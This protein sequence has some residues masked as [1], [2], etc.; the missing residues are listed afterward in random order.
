M[1]FG[2]S[3][4]VPGNSQGMTHHFYLYKSRLQTNL[5]EVAVSSGFERECLEKNALQQDLYLARDVG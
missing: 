3:P 1:V 2:D 5:P 4:A